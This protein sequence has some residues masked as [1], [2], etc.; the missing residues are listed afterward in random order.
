MNSYFTKEGLLTD[1]LPIGEPE[2]LSLWTVECFFLWEM[3]NESSKKKLDDIAPYMRKET[4]VEALMSL[5]DGKKWHPLPDHTKMLD[6]GM[7]LDNMRAITSLGHYLKSIKYPLY[8]DQV[9]L[10]CRAG[11]AHFWDYRLWQPADKILFSYTADKFFG[12]TMLWFLEAMII[13]SLKSISTTGGNLLDTDPKLLA[14]VRL[15]AL[16]ETNEYCKELFEDAENVMRHNLMEYLSEHHDE[17]IEG[18]DPDLHPFKFIFASY[19]KSKDNPINRIANEL[20]S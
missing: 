20:W 10:M 1:I 8:Q 3:L 6:Q 19:F 12:K 5:Y 15:F 2:N 14:F 11:Q 7:S 4:I 18:I 9:A 16:K 13:N 17:E